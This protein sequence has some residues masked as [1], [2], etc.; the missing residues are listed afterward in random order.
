MRRRGG[1]AGLCSDR[2]L[3]HRELRDQDHRDDPRL[4]VGAMVEASSCVNDR[5]RSPWVTI[6]LEVEVDLHGGRRRTG[7]ERWSSGSPRAMPARDAPPAVE[8]DLL[9]VHAGLV[10][11]VVRQHHDRRWMAIMAFVPE[12][13]AHPLTNHGEAEDSR[14]RHRCP[15]LMLA[16]AGKKSRNG[17]L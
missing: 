4:V 16:K 17:C 5:R 10:S 1:R 11:D 15:E 2:A 14:R 7:G 9:V 8:M 3:V 12:H 13:Q 6:T